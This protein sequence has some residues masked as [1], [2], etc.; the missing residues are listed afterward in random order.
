MV[1]WGRE[2]LR[3]GMQRGR[4]EL[5]GVIELLHISSGVVDIQTFT[6]VKTDRIIYFK[7]AH[8]VRC[9]LYS[10]QCKRKYGLNAI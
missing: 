2:W 7:S 6:F 10:Y 8:F 1:A 5:C 4:V 9:K 3:G